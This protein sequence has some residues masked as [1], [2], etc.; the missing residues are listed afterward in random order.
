MVRF[1][2]DLRLLPEKAGSPTYR[3]LGA[4]AHCSAATLADAAAG[5]KLPSLPVT[6]AYVDACGGDVTER[7]TSALR[8]SSKRTPIASSAGRT[9]LTTCCQGCVSAG[10]S[11]CS[12]PPARP[13]TGHRR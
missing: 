7:P 3:V 11:V 2:R 5:H 9:S 1:A 6:V 10:V 12:V 4:R 8:R 13:A